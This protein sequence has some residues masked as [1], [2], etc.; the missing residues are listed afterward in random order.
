MIARTPQGSDV[1]PD[2]EIVR[3]STKSLVRAQWLEMLYNWV[4]C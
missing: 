3:L 2:G 4:V 1:I